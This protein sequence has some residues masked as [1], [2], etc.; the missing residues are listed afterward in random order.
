[1]RQ[2]LAKRNTRHPIATPSETDIPIYVAPGEEAV[3]LPTG[4]V[5]VYVTQVY[6]QAPASNFLPS[7]IVMPVTATGDYNY[8]IEPAA[9]R[10][11]P[12]K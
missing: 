5:K 12:M 9:E 1:M 3:T 6:V 10:H 7:Q 11:F 4:E 8:D 2:I